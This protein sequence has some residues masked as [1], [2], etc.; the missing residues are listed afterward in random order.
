[1]VRKLA[2]SLLRIS[3]VQHPQKKVAE[4]FSHLHAVQF[5]WCGLLALS[6]TGRLGQPLDD[7]NRYNR[8]IKFKAS[9]IAGG[10]FVAV[11]YN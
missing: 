11:S 6:G 2:W 9:Q 10:L 3:T 8:N 1:M 4:I 7:L 5:G